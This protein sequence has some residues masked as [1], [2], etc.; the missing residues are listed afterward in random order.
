MDPLLEVVVAVVLVAAFV[1]CTA[2]IAMSLGAQRAVPSRLSAFLR[3]VA[4]G[5]E[6]V[7]KGERGWAVILFGSL[8][9]AVI[10]IPATD[11]T[12]QLPR[13]DLFGVVTSCTQ[14]AVEIIWIAILW[15]RQTAR[16]DSAGAS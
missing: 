4:D 6:P 16:R 14:L 12:E 13:G 10:A 9:I 3:R 15:F 5:Q 1:L 7:P 11:L 2:I 8:A